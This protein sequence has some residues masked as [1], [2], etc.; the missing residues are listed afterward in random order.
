MKEREKVR[1]KHVLDGGPKK[2]KTLFFSLQFPFLMK[3]VHRQYLL[4][5]V[6]TLS[7]H[8]QT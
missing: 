3:I 1:L 2:Y 6:E 4:P 7:F 8:I 5:S